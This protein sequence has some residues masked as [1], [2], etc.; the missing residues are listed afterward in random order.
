[1][2]NCNTDQLV[3]SWVINGS[4]TPH[5]IWLYMQIA[6]LSVQFRF[7]PGFQWVWGTLSHRTLADPHTPMLNTYSPKRSPGPQPLRNVLRSACAFFVNCNIYNVWYVTL[8]MLMSAAASADA[9][10]AA[11]SAASAAWKNIKAKKIYFYHSIRHVNVYGTYIRVG[12]ILLPPPQKK[13]HFKEFYCFSVH[14]FLILY[15]WFNL[16]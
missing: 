3:N 14:Y 11:S 4:L 10:S 16:A 8:L 9:S 1:M 5:N 6:I 15:L 7:L 2:K 12:F 13:E